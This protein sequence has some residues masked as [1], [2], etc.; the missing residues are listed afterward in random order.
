[1]R[2][3]LALLLLFALLAGG[4]FWQRPELARRLS[5]AL[6]GAP[7]PTQSAPKAAPERPPAKPLV[8]AAPPPP[9]PS[10]PAAHADSAPA[11]AAPPIPAA[12]PANAAAEA[13][14]AAEAAIAAASRA[15]E[16]EIQPAPQPASDPALTL[17]GFDPARVGALIAASALPEPRKA[18]LD[19]A[20]R[21]SAADPA[22]LPLLLE[23]IRSE[24]P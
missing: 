4:L 17:Q 6:S 14:A 7:I 20:L 8:T 10:R 2:I 9:A 21:A 19:K 24:L 15:A 11:P 3:L 1:M 12:P 16:P 22:S 23:Q 13:Q 18:A 5:H